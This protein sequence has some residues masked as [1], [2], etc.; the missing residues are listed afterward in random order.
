MISQ[1]ICINLK[2]KYQKIYTYSKFYFKLCIFKI[3]IKYLKSRLIYTRFFNSPNPYPN[4]TPPF[5]VKRLLL[6]F[7]RNN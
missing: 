3:L 4:E 7:L 1:K 5:S 6:F 2:K